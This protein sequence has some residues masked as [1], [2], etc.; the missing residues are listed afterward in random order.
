MRTLIK[1]FVATSIISAGFLCGLTGDVLKS[2]ISNPR[3]GA[4]IPSIPAA[5]VARLLQPASARAADGAPVNLPPSETYSSVLEIIQSNYYS[6]G[7]KAPRPST[8][9]LTYAAIDG[10]LATLND[11]FTVYWTPKIYQKQ[12]EDTSGN[13]G[14]IGAS[15]DL[16]K[17]KRVLI[18]KVIEDTPALRAGMLPGDIISAVNGKSVVGQDL[19]KVIDQIRGKPGTSVRLTIVRKDKPKPFDLTLNRAIIHS[20]VV[21]FRMED[22]QNKIGYIKLLMFTEQADQDFDAALAQLEKQGMKSLI[23]DLRDNPGGLLNVAQDLASRF[24]AEGPIVW[25]KQ[26]S[27]QMD[28][29]NVRAERHRS[30]LYKGAYPVIVLVN[31]GSASASEIVSGAIQD[32][33][34][35]KLLGTTTYGKGLVQTIFPLDSPVDANDSAVKITTQHYY[36]RDQHDI[37]KKLDANGK[38][39]SGGIKPDYVVEFTEKDYDAV[40]EALRKDPQNRES[41]VRRLDPQLKRARELMLQGI[42][43]QQS[44]KR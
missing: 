19:S 27:G 33:K 14:G 17:D 30:P 20:P 16:T 43:A 31:G 28:S 4:V 41:V 1:G 21:D 5:R 10:M 26:K 37:N 15:L 2:A 3:S 34:V 23:F 9:K 12:M 24:V 13:F 7:A 6:S 8:T 32:S 18:V 44:A 42:P 40:N 35:G 11:P 39:I 29:L 25:V 36:T 38:Q 22:E